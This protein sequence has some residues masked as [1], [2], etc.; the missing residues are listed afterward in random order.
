MRRKREEALLRHKLAG[1][2]QIALGVVEI[3]R[4]CGVAGGDAVQHFGDNL[5]LA[6]GAGQVRMVRMAREELAVQR[7][8]QGQ[9]AGAHLFE[10]ARGRLQNIGRVGAGGQRETEL[11]GVP[12]APQ[13]PIVVGAQGQTM[14][15]EILKRVQGAQ[16]GAGRAIE[17]RALVRGYGGAN[18]LV[19]ERDIALVFLG[20]HL[21]PNIRGGKQIGAGLIEHEGQFVEPRNDVPDTHGQRRICQGQG[22]EQRVAHH[23]DIHRWVVQIALGFL[24]IE[25]GQGNLALDNVQIGAGFRGQG[26]AFH[27]VLQAL[28]KPLVILALLVERLRT[29]VVK[30]F[31]QVL[32]L[33][34]MQAGGSGSNGGKG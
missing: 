3:V 7:K 30:L 8:S 13:T 34:S 24:E 15:Q 14:L 32:T 21:S 22:G 25:Q 19:D 9:H 2:V 6:R 20:R 16:S 26:I 31:I 23:F 28:A 17:L 12:V 10:A 4:G 5:I 11:A 29:D 33:V 1:F 18:C 27:L